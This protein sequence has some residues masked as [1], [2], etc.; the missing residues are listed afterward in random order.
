M[1]VNSVDVINFK[2]TFAK[3]IHLEKAIEKASDYDLYK[4]SKLLNSG[5]GLLS[6]WKNKLG[7]SLIAFRTFSRLCHFLFCE[8]FYFS[9]AFF[10]CL[11]IIFV[12]WSSE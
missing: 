2:G 8:A 12:F 3:N 9:S 1:N 5:D 4:F 7:Y 6:F 10:V 11:V